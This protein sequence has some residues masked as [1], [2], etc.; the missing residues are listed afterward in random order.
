[1]FYSFFDLIFRQAC[2]D[3]FKNDIKKQG[4]LLI[5]IILFILDIFTDKAKLESNLTQLA[6]RHANKGIKAVEYGIIGE[7][8]FWTLDKVLGSAYTPE[9]HVAWRK[10]FSAMLQVII[11]VSIANE[12]KSNAAQRARFGDH[13]QM[14]IGK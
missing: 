13:G 12:L 2:R 1:M 11:P 8:T 9:S 5:T 3:L 7:V 6:I 14:V 10:V 4:E